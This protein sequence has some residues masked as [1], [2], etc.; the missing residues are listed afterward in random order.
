MSRG[1]PPR[2]GLVAGIHQSALIPESFGIC[3]LADI[4]EYRTVVMSA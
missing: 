1:R 2:R 3:V 4:T